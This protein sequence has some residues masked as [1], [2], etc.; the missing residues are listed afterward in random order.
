MEAL[1][2]ETAP[3]GLR[4]LV[5]EP[6]RFRTELLSQTNLQVKQEGNDPTKQDKSED[7]S[8]FYKSTVPNVSKESGNQPG[9][10][11]KLVSIVI[12]LVRKEGVAEGREVPLRMFLGG[13]AWDEVGEKLRKT[14][15]DFEAWEN[16]TR[17]T[18]HV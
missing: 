1:A 6:G 9:D 16:V 11:V 18:D 17:S 4:T 10:P 12:D 5:I 2:H 7:Y 14:I 3:L 13:D 15:K 8:S